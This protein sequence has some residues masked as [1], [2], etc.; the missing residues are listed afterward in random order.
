MQTRNIM[1]VGVGGQGTL[2]ASRIL[3]GI[4][5]TAGLDVKVSEV[6]GMAQRGGSVVTF[7]RYGDEV[8][9]PIV[10][11]GCAD[12]LIAF[13]RLEAK[14]YAHFLKKDGVLI[15]NH[16]LASGMNNA[17]TL[18]LKADNIYM[19]DLGIR[20]DVSY[21]TSMAH[22][23]G[24][25]VQVQGDKSIFQHVSLQGNQDTYY[26]NGAATQRGWF[27][28]GRIEGTVDYIC[29]GGDIWFENVL[30]Y[31]NDRKNDDVIIAPATE[32]PAPTEPP[33]IQIPTEGI[34]TAEGDL[35]FSATFDASLLE[36]GEAVYCI[37]APVGYAAGSYASSKKQPADYFIA[38]DGTVYASCEVWID[39]PL[40]TEETT[41][42][43]YIF[44]NERGHRL[45]SGTQTM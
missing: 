9:E 45:A 33:P 21:P 15:V 25:A 23:V 32:P 30:L 17:E 22:G 29:G 34:S 40:P 7:V 37:Y 39:E 19:Q 13:E 4:A 3:G 5:T 14:R 31:N 18:V 41:T 36:D 20:C 6:H 26:S 42:Y 43:Q 28:D 11:E 12:V 10:E 1:I 44:V 35:C 2:I 27:G 16:P 24:I 38:K 8:F